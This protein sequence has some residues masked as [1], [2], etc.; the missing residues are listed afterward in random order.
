MNR[1][2]HILG[3]VPALWAC[4]SGQ[5]MTL[6]PAIPDGGS[7]QATLTAY[8]AQTCDASLVVPVGTLDAA[9]SFG[10]VLNNTLTFEDS[11]VW[12]Y[13]PISL[14]P[15]QD[16]MGHAFWGGQAQTSQELTGCTLDAAIE[17]QYTAASPTDGTMTAQSSFTVPAGASCTT[18][19]LPCQADASWSL[20]FYSGAGG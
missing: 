1:S 4:G 8:S 9:A 13:G 17:V 2:K 12:R 10:F 6:A 19:K 7:Y 18:L 14:M 3:V 11:S 16:S 5:A 15:A 20:V